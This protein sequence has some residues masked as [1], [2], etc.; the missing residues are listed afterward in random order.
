MWI[1]TWYSSAG[2]GFEK[3]TKEMVRP[4]EL[5]AARTRKMHCQRGVGKRGPERLILLGKLLIEGRS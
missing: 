1:G 2:K 3:G 4:K 5:A